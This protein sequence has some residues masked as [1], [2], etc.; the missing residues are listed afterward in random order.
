MLISS[1]GEKDTD[2]SL[3]IN[4]VEIDPANNVKVLGITID[5]GLKVVKHMSDMG[6]KAGRQISVL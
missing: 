5:Q 6:S 1:K 2:L 3:V 4:D